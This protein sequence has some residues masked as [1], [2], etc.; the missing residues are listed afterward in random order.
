MRSK[1]APT[2]QHVVWGSSYRFDMR[3]GSRPQQP[4]ALI[5][6][7]AAFRMFY[8]IQ[9][10]SF[11]SSNVA[12]QFGL[13]HLQQQLAK[14]PS[15]SCSPQNIELNIN[16]NIKIRIQSEQRERSRGCRQRDYGCAARTCG[17]AATILV[18]ASKLGISLAGKAHSQMQRQQLGQ[19]QRLRQWK[20]QQ[21][22]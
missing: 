1:I 18:I 2:A 7:C 20:R 5:A 6:V 22:T 16:I 13:K 9:F 11:Y 15:G 3:H 21:Q 10:F 4:Q 17:L 19:R 12:F 8:Y 14:R